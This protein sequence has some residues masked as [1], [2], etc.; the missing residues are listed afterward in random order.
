MK[1]L[2]ALLMVLSLPLMAAD[3]GYRIVHPDGTV[4]FTDDETKGGEAVP[5][6]EVPSFQ[7]DRF[8]SGD[9]QANEPGA[10]NADSQTTTEE[11]I[12]AYQ[13]VSIVSPKHDETVW[14]SPDGFQV[15]V[16]VTPE[17]AQGHQVVVHLDGSEAARGEQTRLTIPQVFRGTHTL[18]A[19]VEDG[20]GN[21]LLSSSA[22]TF[23]VRQHSTK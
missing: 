7:T 14:Y 11:E 5:L 23:H 18:K 3:T 16:S 9:V 8:S 21:T 20:A 15:G 22:V 2:F 10:E 17:L 1:G 6:D 13:S 12:V 4:E 19:V